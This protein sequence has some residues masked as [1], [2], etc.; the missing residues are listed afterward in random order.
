VTLYERRQR[1]EERHNEGVIIDPKIY[2]RSLLAQQDWKPAFTSASS[3]VS[4]RKTSQSENLEGF[5]R[6]EKYMDHAGI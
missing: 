1:H 6:S 5:G 4:Q 3:L 2:Q